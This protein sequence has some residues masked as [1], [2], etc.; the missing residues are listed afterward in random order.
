MVNKFAEC[1]GNDSFYIVGFLSVLVIVILVNLSRVVGISLREIEIPMRLFGR[2][3]G[4][5]EFH[6]DDI[7]LIS[8]DVK[9]LHRPHSV[10]ITS[11]H[12]ALSASP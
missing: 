11:A 1:D 5:R 4:W 2:V 9:G 3:V 10:S 12:W 8:K 6:E 7:L